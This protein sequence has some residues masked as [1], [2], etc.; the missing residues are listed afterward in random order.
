M[1]TWINYQNFFL[2]FSLRMQSSLEWPQGSLVHH[3]ATLQNYSRSISNQEYHT[4]CVTSVSYGQQSPS[5]LDYLE[6]PDA[7]QDR[8]F[9]PNTVWSL[10]PSEPE[11]LHFHT[12]WPD[13]GVSV[14]PC[15]FSREQRL[16]LHAD[17]CVWV[18]ITVMWCVGKGMRTGRVPHLCSVHVCPMEG[19]LYFP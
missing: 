11:L 6:F 10:V 2:L 13:T 15:P 5:A 12:V 17:G 4:Q 19:R 7:V 9:H 3:R 1:L 16:Q 14:L 18:Y 8:A